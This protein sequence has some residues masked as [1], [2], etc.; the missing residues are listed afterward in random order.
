ME[1]KDTFDDWF[2][3]L[4][5]FGLKSER[6]FSE[7]DCYLNNEDSI[8]KSE[9]ERIFLSW[10]EAAFNAGVESGQKKKKS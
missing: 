9:G 5:Y 6:F 1:T 8:Q 4:E 3:Q 7:C 2:H 10:L